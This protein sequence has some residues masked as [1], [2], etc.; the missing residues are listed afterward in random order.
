MKHEFEC[1]KIF[2]LKN[3]VSTAVVFVYAYAGGRNEKKKI[4]TEFNFISP[5]NMMMNSKSICETLTMLK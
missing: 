3:E 4:F 5:G 2:Y 1:K